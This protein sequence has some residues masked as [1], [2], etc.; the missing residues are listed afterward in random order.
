M[1]IH[2]D[3]PASLSAHLKCWILNMNPTGSESDAEDLK[4]YLTDLVDE[5]TLSRPVIE[6]RIHDALAN[7]TVSF[8]RT[9]GV[10]EV[11]DHSSVTLIVHGPDRESTIDLDKSR[12]D[13]A[14]EISSSAGYA[15]EL[16]L[17]VWDDGEAEDLVKQWFKLER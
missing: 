2:L 16:E 15:E 10:I 6:K 13:S 1:P 4:R 5:N 11:Y 7:F 12:F 14:D 9:R 3:M 17:A 8:N